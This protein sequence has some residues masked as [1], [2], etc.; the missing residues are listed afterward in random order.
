MADGKGKALRALVL[1]NV[2]SEA[3]VSLSECGMKIEPRFRDRLSA[4][5]LASRERATSSKAAA[6]KPLTA[7]A[8]PWAV[9]EGLVGLVVAVVLD[10]LPVEAVPNVAPM[11]VPVTGLS[12]PV[13]N[14]PPVPAS[15]IARAV[16]RGEGLSVL[17]ALRFGVEFTV[18]NPVVKVA[19]RGGLPPPAEAAEEAAARCCW[20]WS[21]T[22]CVGWTRW[23]LA[24]RAGSLV[25]CRPHR[26]GKNEVARHSQRDLSFAR[27]LQRKRS[28]FIRTGSPSTSRRSVEVMSEPGAGL[29]LMVVSKMVK[30]RVF[31]KGK[32][33]VSVRP[34]LGSLKFFK[35]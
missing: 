15:V 9:V 13:S 29:L 17:V 34:A 30:S 12:T 5:R 32:V 6:E 33:T 2:V 19:G 23:R 35:D 8:R 4:W 1:L 26:L 28:P 20:S 18:V 14:A 22:S 21:S 27:A 25:Q 31:T 11:E 16:G 7:D 3:R 24:T 10:A